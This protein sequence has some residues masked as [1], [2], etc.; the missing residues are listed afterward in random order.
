M[1]TAVY[2]ELLDWTARW[3]R[4]N[5]QG[6]TPADLP[7]LFE[8]L[9]IDEGTWVRFVAEFGRLFWLM[10]GTPTSWI[11][12]LALFRFHVKKRSKSRW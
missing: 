10:T 8:R 5:K 3:V 4:G 9:E 7:P 6:A 2:T 11:P 12:A 1:T